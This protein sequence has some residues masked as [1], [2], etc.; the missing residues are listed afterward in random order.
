MRVV[1]EAVIAALRGHAPLADAV[2]GIFDGPP[3]RARYPYVSMA[4]SVSTDWGT[5]TARGREV[6]VAAMLWDDGRRPARMQALMDAVEDAIEGMAR[7]LDGWRVASLVLRRSRM[8]R[9]ADGPW[10]GLV[11]YRV[12]ILET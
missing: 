12:R 1:Q 9:D 8:V 6:S 3:A 5:K 2:T 7:D 4:E 10:A 11:E